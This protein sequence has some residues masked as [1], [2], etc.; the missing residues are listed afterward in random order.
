[1][2]KIVTC[3]FCHSIFECPVILP[4]C[5]IICEKH[6]EQVKKSSENCEKMNCHFCNEEHNIPRNGFPK[7]IRIAK[8]IEHKF[9]Q[10]DLGKVHKKA[11]D[12]CKELKETINKVKNL[13]K[14]PQNYIEVYFN[15]IINEID[16]LREENKLKINQEERTLKI[17]QWHEKSFNEVQKYKNEYILK[18]KKD[19][20]SQNINI[21]VIELYLKFWQEKLRV[22]LAASTGEMHM[23]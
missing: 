15:K 5:E 11:L 10:M 3:N 8:L 1:M 18:M 4:C 16:L 12:S 14:E 21:G 6:I 13:T 19:F 17:D 7:E 9:H 20:T 23:C 22:V 2:E